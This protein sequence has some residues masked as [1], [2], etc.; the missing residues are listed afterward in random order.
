MG[1]IYRIKIDKKIDK[2]RK[3]DITRITYRYHTEE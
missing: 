2:A 3:T 1:N